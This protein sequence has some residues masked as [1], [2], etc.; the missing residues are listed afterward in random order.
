MNKTFLISWVMALAF[1]TPNYISSGSESTIEFVAEQPEEEPSELDLF[2][3]ALGYQESG[4]RYWVVNRYGY[5]GRYQFGRETLQGLGYYI[6]RKEFLNTPDLQEE[7][8]L[9]LLNHNK[10]VLRNYI[11]H[12]VGRKVYGVKVT[13]SGMLAAAHLVGPEQVKEF[14][15]TGKVARDGN[16]TTM[17]SYMRRFGG[18]ELNLEE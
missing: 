3:D 8:M 11:K 14:L 13:E 4:N 2:L 7:A 15:R 16:N 18:Y 10:F 6:T 12:Y 1:I 17:T 5:M 9:K